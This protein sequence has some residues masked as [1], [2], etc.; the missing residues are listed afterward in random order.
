MHYK[1]NLKNLSGCHTSPV[2][3]KLKRTH[4]NNSL[5]SCFY[6]PVWLAPF[7]GSQKEMSDN[8][9]G[10]TV[11]ATVTFVETV[12]FFFLSHNESER[13][14]QLSIKH[15][16]QYSLT[17]ERKPYKENKLW[18]FHFWLNYNFKSSVWKRFKLK[19]QLEKTNK[20]CKNKSDALAEH[21]PYDDESQQLSVWLLCAHSKMILNLA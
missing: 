12:F 17:E 2:H 18:H 7:L 19:A 9:R 20:L 11:T 10:L 6:K 16:V 8:V 3:P 13:W 15:S 21:F 1:T 14:L 4:V 5:T